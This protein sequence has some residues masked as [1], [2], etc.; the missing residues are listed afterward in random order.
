MQIFVK[1]LTGK[2]I[3][4]EVESSDTIRDVKAMIQAKEGFPPEHQRFIF[5]FKSLEEQCTL[6]DFN[7]QNGSMLHLITRSRE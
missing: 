5:K 1:T 3:P 6:A 7:I 4:L 2:T